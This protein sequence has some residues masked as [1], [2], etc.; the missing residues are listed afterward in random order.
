MARPATVRE[1]IER[2]LAQ[3]KTPARATAMKRA[4]FA[5]GVAPLAAVA[6]ISIA[7]AAPPNSAALEQQR[8]PHTIVAVDSKLLDA[9]AGI[10]K[11]QKTGS[12]MV[13]THEGDH[14]MTSRAPNIP[15]AEYPY[16]NH[17]FFLTVA[18]QQNSF[19]TDSSGAV[20]R[21]VHHQAGGTET[22]ERLSTE[23]G[24]REV[25][26]INQRVAEENTP[27]TEIS[28]DPKLLDNYVGA[29]QLN[30]RMVFTVTRDGDKLFARLT[31]QKTFDL[32]PYTD[33][34]F[35]YTIVAAQLSFVQGTDGPA[36]AVI[37]HQ[38]GHDQTAER[39]DL[40][41]A[42]ALDR[43]R[44]EESKPRT[45]IAI[46]PELIGRYIGRYLNDNLEIT[47]SREGNQ[48]FIQVTGFARYPVY[49]YTDHD[50]FATIMPAQISFWAD[51]NS[52]AT[53]LIRHQFGRDVVLNRVD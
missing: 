6:A 16:T 5:L 29:Y 15:V 46:D 17:D 12:I 50:F 37:L 44:E 40:A 19:M 53:Q 21:V 49:P 52:N 32:H 1:R 38:N 43:N 7:D 23:D 26:A 47:A 27:R 33:H 51:G 14:L 30:P 4:I 39:V 20:V 35:F 45:A 28:I 42:Q 11:N 48:L 34:D 10:Y 2:I 3:D 18:S 41:S 8:G 31:G 36:S 22:L 25:A 13:V 24:Q 9:Y